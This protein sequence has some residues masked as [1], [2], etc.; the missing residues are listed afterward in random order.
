MKEMLQLFLL[1]EY[2]HAKLR[3]FC[4]WYRFYNQKC[5]FFMLVTEELN[6]CTECLTTFSWNSVTREFIIPTSGIL[7]EHE[8]PVR[9]LNQIH[10]K[11]ACVLHFR[12]FLHNVKCLKSSM[13]PCYFICTQCNIKFSASA[14]FLYIQV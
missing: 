12:L 9:Y 3:L 7:C 6:S 8:I 5:F 2:L 1:F 4:S 13:L 11:V 14:C 10:L